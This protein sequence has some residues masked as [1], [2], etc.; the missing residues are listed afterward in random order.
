MECCRRWN[1]L[2]RSCVM[3]WSGAARMSWKGKEMGRLPSSSVTTLFLSFSST[4]TIQQSTLN[5][6]LHQHMYT[7]L[8]LRINGDI[9]INFQFLLIFSTSVP[10]TWNR[11]A[12]S[13]FLAHTPFYSRLFSTHHGMPTYLQTHLW[14]QEYSLQSSANRTCGYIR[15]SMSTKM[16]FTFLFH[17]GFRRM[18]KSFYFFPTMMIKLRGLMCATERCYSQVRG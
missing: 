6:I 11:E 10:S 5:K 1:G 16:N 15:L 17:N 13:S 8:T 3:W 9:S 18:E 4:T 2:L 12:N 7:R 14:L